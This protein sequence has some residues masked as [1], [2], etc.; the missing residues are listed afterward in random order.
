MNEYK[1]VSRDAGKIE[2]RAVTQTTTHKIVDAMAY[3]DVIPQWAADQIRQQQVS[4][5]MQRGETLT[6]QLTSAS[7][8]A[9]PPLPSKQRDERKEK[10]MAKRLMDTLVKQYA[11]DADTAWAWMRQAHEMGWEW[12]NHALGGPTASDPLG[13]RVTKSIATAFSNDAGVYVGIC[14]VGGAVRWGWFRATEWG[15]RGRD[16]VLAGDRNHHET[17]IAAIA[18]FAL[19]G[20]GTPMKALPLDDVFGGSW[21]D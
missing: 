7:G 20:E 2:V 11:P 3:D 10:M 19:L 13:Q 6:V 17:P 12:G 8:S 1:V 15:P 21:D 9:P 4:T 5:M 18:E 14:L 16:L